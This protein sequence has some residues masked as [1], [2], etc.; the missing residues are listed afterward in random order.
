MKH[1]S[2]A[3]FLSCPG[4]GE[5]GRG[6]MLLDHCM[7]VN[8]GKL[9]FVHEQLHLKGVLDHCLTVNCGKLIFVHEQLHLK[10]VFTF[11][12]YPKIF[13]FQMLT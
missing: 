3:P 6:H 13:V 4:K 7:S 11:G 12:N 1:V 2:L 8:C 10:G 5:G 9:I